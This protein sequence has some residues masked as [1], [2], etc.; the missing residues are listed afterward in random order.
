MS[1]T[2]VKI[3]AFIPETHTDIVHGIMD[4]YLLENI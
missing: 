2:N 3:V 4:V 1:S